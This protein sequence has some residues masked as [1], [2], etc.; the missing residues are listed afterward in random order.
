MKGGLLKREGFVFDKAGCSVK[1][2]S[3][4]T[5]GSGKGNVWKIR[6]GLCQRIL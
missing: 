3:G 1:R 4:G 6:A 5:K 2:N